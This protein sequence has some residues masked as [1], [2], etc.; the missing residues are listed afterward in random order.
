MSFTYKF[1]KAEGDGECA[2]NA[3]ILGLKQVALSG[4]LDAHADET[5]KSFFQFSKEITLFSKEIALQSKDPSKE[6]T[7]P[8]TWAEF[9]KFLINTPTIELQKKL[10]FPLFRPFAISL[11]ENQAGYTGA[12]HQSNTLPVLTSV[13]RNYVLTQL[14]QAQ[15]IQV[16]NEDDLFNIPHIEAKFDELSV[17]ILTH[18]EFVKF[19]ARYKALMKK[20]KNSKEQIEL[21][22]LTEQL[23]R[24]IESVQKDAL[25]PWWKTSGHTDFLNVMKQQEKWA[26]DLELAPLAEFFGVNL[27]I[28]RREMTYVMH[29]DYGMLDA[30]ELKLSENSINRMI[31]LDLID[32]SSVKPG[33]YRWLNIPSEQELDHRLDAVPDS[34][35]VINYLDS[36][37]KAK[38]FIGTKIETPFFEAVSQQLVDNNIIAKDGSNNFVFIADEAA[39]RLAINNLPA[40]KRIATD[41]VDRH[42][43]KV[44]D[45]S[46][47]QFG[48]ACLA[49][50]KDHNIIKADL[51]GKGIF[52][53]PESEVRLRLQ[54]VVN[55]E[56]REKIVASWKLAHRNPE[57][58]L[59]QNKDARHWDYLEAVPSNTKQNAD[60]VD[61]ENVS[62]KE[63]YEEL[64]AHKDLQVSFDGI[65]AQQLQNLFDKHPEEPEKQLFKQAFNIALQE[66]GIFKAKQ[67]ASPGAPNPSP[68]LKR[69]TK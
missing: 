68:E 19:A 11:I 29:F 44:R 26:G 53:V 49:R 7:L 32:K 55:K 28:K 42:I 16:V 4:K 37:A 34:D 5:Y 1:V 24:I 69:P 59:L 40:H 39:T 12:A 6:I 46:V 47:P 62:S 60:P 20:Q 63:L 38:E 27:N 67:N 2:F 54:E 36:V 45:S 17:K 58:I 18:V 3:F 61:E 33:V 43:D 57:T 23:E 30:A 9:K 51:S 15:N 65:F 21:D 56:T 10:A 22:N 52:I 8:A 48:D 31:K 64:K 35:N 14:K 25:A 13:F 41:A 66:Y 50:L